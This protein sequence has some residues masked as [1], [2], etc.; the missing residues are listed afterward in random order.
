MHN[1]SFLIQLYSIV[2]QPL[3]SMPTARPVDE[4]ID[5]VFEDSSEEECWS[6]P[7]EFSQQLS[8]TRSFSNI[9]SAV[10]S[11]PSRPATAIQLTTTPSNKS[12]RRTRISRSSMISRRFC[13]N[14]VVNV[15]YF[16]FFILELLNS[17]AIL[18]AF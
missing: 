2:S 8:K 16:P 6:K 14:L 15:G 1:I 7:S 5:K 13:P 18:V 9:P 11:K 12:I 4:L 3:S 17:Q 10:S